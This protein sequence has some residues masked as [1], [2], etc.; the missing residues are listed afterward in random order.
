[1]RLEDIRAHIRMQPFHPIRVFVSDGSHYDILH[2]DFMIVG[3]SQVTIGL[4]R[5][6]DDFPD[7]NAYVDPVHITRIEPINGKKTRTN[8]R[9]S[10][11]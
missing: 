1:M 3:R 11:A 7:Q 6:A 10:S 9:K 5:A 4:A 2:H 8:G